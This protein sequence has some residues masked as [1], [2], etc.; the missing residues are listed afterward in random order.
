MERGKKGR[1]EKKGEKKNKNRRRK[2]EKE[3]RR[4]KDSMIAGEIIKEHGLS[5]FMAAVFLAGELA[6][7]GALKLPAALVGTGKISS[8]F[9]GKAM[10]VSSRYSVENG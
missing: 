2:K 3:A 7:S 10:H 5:V 1:E 8:I 4:R 6:G 9:N